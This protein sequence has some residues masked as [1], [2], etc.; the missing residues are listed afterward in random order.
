[1]ARTFRRRNVQHPVSELN[2]TNLIDVA[3]TLL[4]IFMIATPL[5]QQE[6]AIEVTLPTESKREQAKPDKDVTFQTIGINRA[7]EY[8]WGNRKIDF[9][10]LPDLLAAA[11]RQEKPPVL[12]IRA[13]WSLQYQK[14]ISLMDE[15]KKH[16]LNKL[17]FDTQTTD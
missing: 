4:I 7:G 16:N 14:V 12:R 8:F 5:I 13:D 11:A 1:M 6:Q 10:E 17:T 3:F 15:I 9:Q 2:V